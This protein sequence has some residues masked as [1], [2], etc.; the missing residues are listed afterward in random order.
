MMELETQLREQIL[1][2]HIRNALLMQQ[3]SAYAN[4]T[5]QTI[6]EIRKDVPSAVSVD[7]WLSQANEKER[8]ITRNLRDECVLKLRELRTCIEQLKDSREEV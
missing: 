1:T 2:L 8:G 4:R 5:D 6:R 3:F 7:R